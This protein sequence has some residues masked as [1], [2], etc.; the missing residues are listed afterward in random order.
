MTAALAALLAA[1]GNAVTLAALVL[2][3]AAYRWVH[4]D[5]PA[6][7]T[8]ETID[9]RVALFLVR[10]EVDRA[11]IARDSGDV[12]HARAEIGG[13]LY[14]VETGRI[15]SDVC[16]VCGCP[17]ELHADREEGEP[18]EVAIDGLGVVPC[19]SVADRHPN[20]PWNRWGVPVLYRDLGGVRDA[21]RAW[22]GG[23]R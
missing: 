9:E 4:R 13:V 17:W 1:Y 2:V 15:A 11:A 7:E 14:L 16:R 23:D 21:L 5:V 19:T 22:F 6:V 18:S 10:L 20:T 12:F 8:A 3:R